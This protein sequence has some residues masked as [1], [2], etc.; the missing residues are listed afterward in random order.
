MKPIIMD[1]RE[2][3]LSKEVY[4]KKPQRFFSIF[5]YGL[6]VIVITA[7]VWAYFG[8][9]D[10]VVR[11]HGII[12]PHG[13]TA[14]VINTV[15]GKIQGVFFYEGQRVSQGDVLYLVDTFHLENERQQLIE[16]L[17]SL[18]FELASLEL[19]RDSIEAGENL[20]GSFNG[21]L[22]SRFD[23]F[24]VNIAAIEH[25]ASN[26]IHLLQEEEQAFRDAIFYADF[27]LDTLRAFENSILQG[28]DLFG[29]VVGSGR[30]REIRN[31][32]RNQYLRY[33]LEMEDL[34]FQIATTRASLEGYQMIRASI[35]GGENLFPP[36]LCIYRSMYDEHML[37]QRQLVESYALAY[38]DYL[39]YT[40]LYQAG[41]VALMEKQAAATR[42]NNIRASIDESGTNFLLR[43]DNLSRNADIR[44]SQLE[45]QAELL[46][47]G[48]LAA[49]SG[50]MLALETS[51]LEMNH[52]LTQTMRQKEAIFFVG[53]EAGDAANLRLGEIA[54]NLGQ[55]NAIS[56]DITRISL[57]I[58]GIDAQINESTVRASIG[59]KVSVHTELIEGGFVLGGE[60][61]LSIIPTR[62]E[63]LNANIFVS[64]ADIGQITEG[65]IVRYEIA[66][67]PRRDF[68]EI[69]GVITRISSDV[70]AENGLFR[71]ESDIEDR[72]YYDARGNGVDLRVGMG[73]EARIIVEEQRILFYLL[74]RL[75]L[76]LN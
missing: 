50:K 28:R 72:T 35:I 64:N 73:F 40:A 15:P 1:M 22:S 65:M 5:I 46:H 4:D 62:E 51:A 16:Q 60:Q 52:A 49:I 39:I 33:T 11:A 63:M 18:N 25:G 44:L 7:L 13:Q 67:L 14:L 56:Q 26:Q 6:L 74:D 58:A 19:F 12:R 41:A 76:M 47:I 36:G 24:L 21:E 71:V 69:T 29:G 68:G 59:G 32:Y 43:I 70:S 55:I 20:I 57:G 23:A 66:A 27:E 54:R 42:L 31:T 17:D 2:M 75:N 48:T 45:N 37:H 8:R 10:I 38:E 9:L 3:S 34:R 53:Y 61:V 30:S